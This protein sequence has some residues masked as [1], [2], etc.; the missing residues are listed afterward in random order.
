MDG[1]TFGTALISQFFIIEAF[2]YISARLFSSSLLFSLSPV[3]N[4]QADKFDF[5]SS[6]YTLAQTVQICLGH[7]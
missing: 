5:G 6:C 3:G 1:K 4:I 2:V 7:A